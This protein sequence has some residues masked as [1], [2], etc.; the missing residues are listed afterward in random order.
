MTC[1]GD[2]FLYLIIISIVSLDEK[3]PFFILY[4]KISFEYVKTV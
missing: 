2:Y 3:N 4:S 1:Q